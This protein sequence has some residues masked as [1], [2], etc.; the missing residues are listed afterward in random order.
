MKPGRI[1]LPLTS[2]TCASA[3]IGTSPR[4][5][6]ARN[7]PASITMTASSMGGRPVPS[8]SF[9]PCTTSTFSAMFVFPSW[10]QSSNCRESRYGRGFS[11]AF[12]GLDVQDRHRPQCG[13]RFDFH[14][15]AA[16]LFVRSGVP[17]NVARGAVKI[18]QVVER[19]ERH[20][21][22]E[23]LSGL[24]E[25]CNPFLVICGC[26]LFFDE[27]IEFRIAVRHSLRG[28]GPKVLVVDS[29]GIDQAASA[30]I[31]KRQFAAVDAGGPP[32]NR[33]LL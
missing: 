24:L 25:E 8:I 30:D 31:V 23:N 20:V 16:N 15:P 9:P 1:V 28:P 14:V 2:I 4:R 33:P 27:L 18:R 21:L 13:S 32:E 12:N 17:D 5:P 3:G 10:F 6:T 7:L 19:H 11:D 26:L 22:H 29:V